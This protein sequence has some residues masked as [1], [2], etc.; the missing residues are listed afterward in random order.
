MIKEFIKELNTLTE[1]DWCRYAFS[2]EPLSGKL[3]ED[4][5]LAYFRGA[6]DFG[7]SLALTVKEQMGQLTIAEY[8]VR[9]GINVT[10]EEAVLDGIYTMFASFTYPDSIT[11]YL[12]NAR[13]TDRMIEEEGLSSVTGRVRTEDLLLAH[14]L[15]HFYENR[16]PDAYINQKHILLFKI[17]RFENRSRLICLAEIAAMAFAKTLT[18]LSCSPYLY[19]VLMLYSRNPQRG[20]QQYEQIMKI[21]EVKNR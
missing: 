5:R 6:V 20:K 1:Q 21:T 9:E 14:E 8:A 17:G 2:S 12:N 4:M 15:F 7:A 19:D 3:T 11:I 18:E 13:A 10:G 16:M